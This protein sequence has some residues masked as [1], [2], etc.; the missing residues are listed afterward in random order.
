MAISEAKA[1]ADARWRKKALERIPFDV[2]RDAEINGDVIR[3]HAA[4][5][6]ESV[7][8]FLK[9]AVTETIERDKQNNIEP[10]K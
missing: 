2:R 10:A 1:K 6:G 4:S 3:A 7:N 8:G 9:R 5:R